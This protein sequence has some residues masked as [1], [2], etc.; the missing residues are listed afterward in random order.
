VNAPRD[1]IMYGYIKEPVDF[2]VVS[3]FSFLLFFVSWRFFHLVE[4]KI[5]ERI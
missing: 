1:L 4:T 5:P 2:F 3:A